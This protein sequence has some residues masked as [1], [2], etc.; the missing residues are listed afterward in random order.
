MEGKR[1]FL[2]AFSSYNRSDNPKEDFEY[3]L[4]FYY[5][6]NPIDFKSWL[7]LFIKVHRKNGHVGFAFLLMALFWDIFQARF[8]R[9][10]FLSLQGP[11]GA[12]KGQLMDSLT[13]FFGKVVYFNMQTNSSKFAFNNHV[14]RYTNAIS[15]LNE[16]NPSSLEEYYKLSPKA[17]Y[18]G[19]ARRKGSMKNKGK[20]TSEK[21]NSA[22]I[23][24][25]QESFYEFEASVSRGII[26]DFEKT[27][28]GT[29]ETLLKN[30]L[31]DLESEG[32]TGLSR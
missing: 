6:D 3:E 27:K 22:Q 17:W 4:G 26:C 7:D 8:G 23:F 24:T 5:T 25:G 19:E 2:E 12:G 1:Y 15:I 21:P 16:F 9:V 28:F 30:K 31:E 14:G 13:A 29:K 18:D 11:K 10:P 20:T 32:I